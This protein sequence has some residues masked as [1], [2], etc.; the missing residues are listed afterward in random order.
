MVT[1]GA[2]IDKSSNRR[3]LEGFPIPSPATATH[4]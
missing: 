3:D 1:F 2:T 4:A